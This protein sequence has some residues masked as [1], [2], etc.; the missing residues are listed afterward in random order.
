VSELTGRKPI[1]V[2]DF[3]GVCHSYTSG[4]KGANVI[5]DPPVPGMWEALREY[6]AHFE[7]NILSSRTHQPGGLQ[8]MREWFLNHASTPS[9]RVVFMAL[10]F[11]TDKPPA[12]ITIDDRG[13][14]FTG[15][16]PS[17]E[18]LK[19]FR[20]WYQQGKKAAEV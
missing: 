8:A 20:P 16:W 3:D 6:Q 9:Q 14:T 19:N 7:V 4:W 17:L 10:R 12:L 15:T 13:I 18:S 11:P 2:L 5:P 1:L